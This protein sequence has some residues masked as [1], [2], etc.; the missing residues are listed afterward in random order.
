[1]RESGQ[2]PVCLFDYISG[3]PSQF[4]TCTRYHALEKNRRNNSPHKSRTIGLTTL[5]SSTCCGELSKLSLLEKRLQ[6]RECGSSPQQKL[7]L[8]SPAQE[9][10]SLSPPTA[11]GKPRNSG[12][13]KM[14]SAI[15]GGRHSM[16]N[17]TFKQSERTEFAQDMHRPGLLMI[18]YL[19]A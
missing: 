14:Q 19:S 6:H 4:E 2:H 7:R 9:R 1:M 3:N 11:N 17:F 18:Y 13:G 10:A 5:C 16:F 15:A 12:R 8:R